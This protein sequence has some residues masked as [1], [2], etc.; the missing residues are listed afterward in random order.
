MAYLTETSVK[1]YLMFKLPIYLIFILLLVTFTC[2][3]SIS[4]QR[5]RGDL[6]LPTAVELELLRRAVLERF[7][8]EAWVRRYGQYTL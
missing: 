1:E 7:L 2:F 6:K 5:P 4:V 8:D 3:T